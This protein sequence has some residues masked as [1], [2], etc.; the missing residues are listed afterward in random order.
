M[1]LLEGQGSPSRARNCQKIQ[2]WCRWQWVNRA[3][4]CGKLPNVQVRRYHQKSQSEKFD[5]KGAQVDARSEA[6]AMESKAKEVEE[7]KR[8]EMHGWTKVY[9]TH[10]QN[11]CIVLSIFKPC[12]LKAFG[13]WEWLKASKSNAL[14]KEKT[15]EKTK[16]HFVIDYRPIISKEAIERIGGRKAIGWID[17]SQ[18]PVDNSNNDSNNDNNNNNNN[19]NKNIQLSDIWKHNH[20]YYIPIMITS[21]STETTETTCKA[22]ET[23]IMDQTPLSDVEKCV[24][25]AN[26]FP[27]GIPLQMFK[28]YY[29]TLFDENLDHKVFTSLHPDQPSL[30]HTSVPSLHD[31]FQ[32][33]V[34]SFSDHLLCKKVSHKLG[35]TFD[36][37][38]LIPNVYQVDLYLLIKKK[39]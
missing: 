9:C 31:Y 4:T 24:C 37:L 11:G 20:P 17:R 35:D 25:I 12:F 27:Q 15:K 29:R 36:D 34:T 14:K 2:G 5:G 22:L 26:D 39:K 18:L 28:T 19:N 33:F 3:R 38:L 1:K 21:T 32:F 7:E 10:N 8:T 6:E 23:W 30:D 16:V 13:N